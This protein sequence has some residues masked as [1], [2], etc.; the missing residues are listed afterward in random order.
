MRVGRH[1]NPRG[2]AAYGGRDKEG[3]AKH[4]LL[5]RRTRA[6][7]N[8]CRERLGGA[9]RGREGHRGRCLSENGRSPQRERSGPTQRQR[10]H[11][12]KEMEQDAHTDNSKAKNKQGFTQQGTYAHQDMLAGTLPIVGSHTH[13]SRGSE[14][15]RQT[16]ETETRKR[17]TQRRLGSGRQTRKK[18][19]YAQAKGKGGTR[20]GQPPQLETKKKRTREQNPRN[21]AGVRELHNSLPSPE[22]QSR[23]AGRATRRFLREGGTERR[24]QRK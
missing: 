14:N 21:R 3:N 15:E 24:R 12:V 16:S 10:S 1:Q 19:A 8:S 7:T 22:K 9:W 13:S 4:E 17:H 2:V 11:Q 20:Q 5:T 23:T 6:H 18:A